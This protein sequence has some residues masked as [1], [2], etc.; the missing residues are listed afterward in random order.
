L[1]AAF[2]REGTFLTKCWLNVNDDES[3]EEA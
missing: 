1:I 3:L 2:D